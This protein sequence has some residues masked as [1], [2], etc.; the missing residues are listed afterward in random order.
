M[1][2]EI[3]GIILLAYKNRFSLYYKPGHCL[4]RVYFKDGSQHKEVGVTII[5]T[6]NK[7]VDYLRKQNKK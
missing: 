5:E 4:A 7:M 1:E 3:N 6:I 2:K